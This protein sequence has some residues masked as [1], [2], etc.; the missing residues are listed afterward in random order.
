MK[1]CRRARWSRRSRRCRLKRRTLFRNQAP[2]LGD[3][4]VWCVAVF[5]VVVVVVAA[6]A[7]AAAVAVGIVAAA[8]AVGIVA[9]AVVW[10][11]RSPVQ[12]AFKPHH[13]PAASRHCAHVWLLC[14]A[15]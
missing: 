1:F 14:F 2:T 4:L 8:V 6:A 13:L 12:V 10:L 7:A 5:V 9:A 11:W 3:E 15:S